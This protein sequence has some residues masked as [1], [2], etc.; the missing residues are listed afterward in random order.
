M[1]NEQ[2]PD[3]K[4]WQGIKSKTQTLL[5]SV[6]KKEGRVLSFDTGKLITVADKLPISEPKAT[7][8]MEFNEEPPEFIPPSEPKINPSFLY[9][10]RDKPSFVQRHKQ[11]TTNAELLACL[12]IVLTFV[13]IVLFNEAN[14]A[15]SKSRVPGGEFSV[16]VE[17]DVTRSDF[18][19][20][21]ELKKYVKKHEQKFEKKK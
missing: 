9:T 19:T 8:A 11:S 17:N 1:N 14:A 21:K 7:V 4:K 3:K 15:E 18:R 13:C 5:Q 10:K 16:L 12:F 6:P 20:E 2:I